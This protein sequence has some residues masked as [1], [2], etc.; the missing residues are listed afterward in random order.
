[1]LY[2]SKAMTYGDNFVVGH[3][4]VG[5]HHVVEA[6]NHGMPCFRAQGSPAVFIE[7]DHRR[8]VH[9]GNAA[10]ELTQPVDN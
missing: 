10:A 4:Q 9:A 3:Y 8:A 1:M 7:I 5:I 2:R 6:S